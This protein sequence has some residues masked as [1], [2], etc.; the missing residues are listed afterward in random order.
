MNSIKETYQV[1]E[2]SVLSVSEVEEAKK[3]KSRGQQFLVIL[4]SLDGITEESR[5]C[6][7]KLFAYKCSDAYKADPA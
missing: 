4:S 2:S 3:K 7:L 6:N 5:L 1:I